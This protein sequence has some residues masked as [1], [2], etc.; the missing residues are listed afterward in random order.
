MYTCVCIGKTIQ[1]I[2]STDCSSYSPWSNYWHDHYHC[3]CHRIF[4][5][6]QPWTNPKKNPGSMT[7][8]LHGSLPWPLLRRWHTPGK[9]HPQ[10]AHAEAPP[11]KTCEN[12]GSEID[13][14][15]VTII[16]KSLKNRLKNLGFMVSTWHTQHGIHLAL[17]WCWCIMA[18]WLWIEVGQPIFAE[19]SS[20]VRYIATTNMF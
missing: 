2:E 14:T 11:G 20:L 5:R 6:Y 15:Q 1:K 4:L 3:H 18:M 9:D 17:M 19:F 12:Q 7:G 8:L 13:V 16:E 10:R